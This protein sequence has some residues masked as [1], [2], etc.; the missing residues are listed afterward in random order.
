MAAL[1]QN[2]TAIIGSPVTGSR[3]SCR[4]IPMSLR[5]PIGGIQ[6]RRPETMVVIEALVGRPPLQ[7]GLGAVSY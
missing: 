3:P 5:P 7:L 2:R 4:I 6:R 1:P